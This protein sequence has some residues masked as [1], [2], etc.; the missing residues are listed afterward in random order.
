MHEICGISIEEVETL[1][2]FLDPDKVGQVPYNDMLR[3]FKEPKY[4]TEFARKKIPHLLDEDK[5]EPER[6]ARKELTR[7][8][9]SGTYESRLKPTSRESDVSSPATQSLSKYASIGSR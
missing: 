8:I 2:S 4:L 6:L 7:P 9:L 5:F 1:Q 3:L